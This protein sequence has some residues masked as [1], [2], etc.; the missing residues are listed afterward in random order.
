MSDSTALFLCNSLSQDLNL[1]SAIDVPIDSI[2]ADLPDSGKGIIRSQNES[3]VRWER[4]REMGQEWIT[5]EDSLR[6]GKCVDVVQLH[7]DNSYDLSSCFVLPDDSSRPVTIRVS[8]E[9]CCDSAFDTS[10]IQ[11]DLWLG[12]YSEFKYQGFMG[13]IDR[14]FIERAKN[15]HLEPGDR[16]L[17]EVEQC[18]SYGVLELLCLTDCS[19]WDGLLHLPAEPLCEIEKTD[20]VSVHR[21]GM[22][23]FSLTVKKPFAKVVSASLTQGD[24]VTK[25]NG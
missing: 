20:L 16:F 19:R 4:Y 13:T 10:G 12:A 3:P 6:F 25:A 23:G 21:V 17:V 8:L 7:R 18:Q 24:A 11:A 2:G 1:F 15:R 14:E 9:T 22:D 5:Q